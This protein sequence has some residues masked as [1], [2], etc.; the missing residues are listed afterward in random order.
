MRNLFLLIALISFWS[1]ESV[2]DER[3]RIRNEWIDFTSSSGEGKLN[4]NSKLIE[5]LNR[6]SECGEYK[7]VKPIITWKE[8][9]SGRNMYADTDG[10]LTLERNGTA[11]AK[12]KRYNR[13]TYSNDVFTTSAYWFIHTSKFIW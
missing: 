6:K 7:Y 9:A 5:I 8:D 13:S 1:C 11:N 12:L 10:S 4:R 3:T 2:V